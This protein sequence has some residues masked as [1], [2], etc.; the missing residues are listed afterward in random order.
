MLRISSLYIEEFISDSSDPSSQDT[1][2]SGNIMD[3]K[4]VS[5]SWGI[6]DSVNSSSLFKLQSV[7]SKSLESDKFSKSPKTKSQP[8]PLFRGP[9]ASFNGGSAVGSDGKR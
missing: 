9:W 5:L 8:F 7:T 4:L 6:E 1:P 3:T 2:S